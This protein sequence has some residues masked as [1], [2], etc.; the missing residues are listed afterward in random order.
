MFKT[1]QNKLFA[2]LHQS[3]MVI[4]LCLGIITGI[5]LGFIFKINYFA[6]PIWLL[7]AIMLLLV[8]YLKP[9]YA[10]TAIALIAGMIIA[11]FRIS[12]ELYNQDYVRS[13]WGKT[14]LV[15]GTV[16]GDPETDI[17]ATKFQLTNLEFNGVPNTGSLYVTLAKNENL[18]RAD[19][20]TLKGNLSEGFGTYVGYMYKP[21][22]QKW[23]RPS[24]GDF[25]LAVR[26]WFA[27]RIATLIKEPEINLGLSY[28]LGLK[29]GLP[30]ELAESLRIIGLTHIIVASGTHLS[31]LVEIAR[32]I[33]GR[34]SRFAG[35]L[36][37]T[38]FILFFM[39]MV[40]WT[41]SILRAGLMAILS[42]ILWYCGRKITPWR[43]I[44]LVATFTLM[45]NPNFIIDLGW[46]LSFASYTG[47]MILSPKLTRFF[48]GGKKPKLIGSTIIATVSATLMTLPIIL[49]YYG[50]VSLISI[51][52]NLLIL[53]TL[54]YAMGL[55]FLTGVFS[56]V[57]IVGTAIG[58]CSTKL[59]NFHI[60]IVEWLG[61]MRQFLIEINPYQNW[62]FLLYLPILI[63]LVASW[64]QKRRITF[65]RSRQE[66]EEVVE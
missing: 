55:T 4:A 7:F 25:I 28:L 36:F 57:P 34:A 45:L 58:W 3:W 13:L 18:K 63:L 31:I 59:L 19:Q 20:V 32:K 44:L 42:L 33:F 10:L 9:K 52:A 30:E 8:A 2:S 48:Y 43:L 15:S 50:T 56:E 1:L 66:I 41:P 22:L 14:I 11:F 64:L 26:N 29:S 35:L 24:P 60:V 27:E 53:P 65:S 46:L 62:V 47:I 61:S 17:D 51:I 5:I 16:K 6:S 23:E 54:P 38:L 21:S 40:G 49:Y 12:I 37:S 39:S